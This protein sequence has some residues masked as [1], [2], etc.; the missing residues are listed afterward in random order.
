MKLT[1][2]LAK[3]KNL[4]YSAIYNVRYK[5]DPIED[6]HNAMVFVEQFSGIRTI[7]VSMSNSD[8]NGLS[9]VP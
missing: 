1:F 4:T 9:P 6:A 3:S 5:T 8:T 7:V 2:Y